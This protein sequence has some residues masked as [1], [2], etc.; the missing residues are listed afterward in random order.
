M[1]LQIV[2][3]NWNA[4]KYTNLSSSQICAP[5]GIETS[6]SW[7]EKAIDTIQEIDRRMTKATNDPNETLYLIQRLSVAI[8]RGNTAS[9]LNTFPEVRESHLDY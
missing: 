3:L 5:I 9:F 2:Q 6:G 8:Q 1:P 7:N 4:R